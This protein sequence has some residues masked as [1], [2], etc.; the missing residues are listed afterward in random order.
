MA[1]SY[2]SRTIYPDALL[3]DDTFPF[4]FAYVNQSDV[5]ISID[6]NETLDFTFIDSNT[7]KLNTPLTANAVVTIYRET[8]L[9]SRVVDFQNAAEL[10]EKDL[11]DSANQVFYATQE[12]YDIAADSIK[13]LPDGTFSLSGRRLKD[14]AY[15]EAATD[16]ANRK[17]V[18]DQYG[19]NSTLRDDLTN[20]KNSAAASASAAAQNLADSQVLMLEVQQSVI[21]ASASA[22]EA[23]SAALSAQNDASLATNSAAQAQLVEATTLAARDIAVNAANSASADSASAALSAYNASTSEQNA[24]T[25]AQQAEAA[26]TGA[27]TY[28]GIWDATQGKPID[29][30]VS[31]D[32][33]KYWTITVAGTITGIGYVDVGY[34]III[35]EA[36]AYAIIPLP[37]VYIKRGNNLSE[38]VDKAAARTN[39]G[40]TALLDGK[41]AT[42]GT[43]P[44]LRAQAT[45][46]EDVGL[47]NIP[48]AVTI[49]RTTDDAAQLLTAKAMF[50]HNASGDHDSRYY[51]KVEVAAMVENGIPPGLIALW[52]G[53]LVDIPTGWSLCDGIN[54]TIDL[55]DKFVVGAGGAYA[56]GA[57]GGS[58]DAVVVSHTHSAS[59]ASG[60][61]H[62]HTGSAS[63]AGAHTHGIPSVSGL[64]APGGSY[65]LTV[66]SHPR[67]QFNSD[68]TYSS[69]AHTHTLTINSGGDHTHTVTVDSTGED[70]VGKNLPPYYALA[71]IQKVAA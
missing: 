33:G 34:D 62:T 22:Q 19:I 30:P 56:V 63:S 15:P 4:D 55:R 7:I 23:S 21:Y 36:L 69:G 59:T 57:T 50:D 26:A 25:Y 58:S 16:G 61:A 48:N 40:V 12:A 41:A 14:L 9:D 45:T 5:H 11:D 70:G 27:K 43:Y 64:S 60:G 51:T 37:N 35:T 3:G 28:V 1:E 20:D 39:L 68:Y 44:G 54:G 6:G 47:S 32:T 71:F 66:F 53:A 67:T 52:S 8:F 13:P 49:S 18:D 2:F 65:D 29:T 42:S 38:V 10:T 17:Y 31:T 46:K 24:L